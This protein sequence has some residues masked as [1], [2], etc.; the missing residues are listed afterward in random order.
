MKKKCLSYFK[1][2]IRKYNLHAFREIAIFAIIT[3]IIHN[4]PF[5]YVVIFSMWVIWVEKI[6]KK[7]KREMEC[8][9]TRNPQ[10]ASRN[11]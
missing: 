3:I 6:S 2:F 4:N 9:D 7:K 8:F 1:N 5:F 10:S 11:P